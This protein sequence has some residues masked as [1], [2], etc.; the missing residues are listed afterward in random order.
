MVNAITNG[1]KLKIDNAGRI[2]LPK[3]V[4]DRLGLRAG[5]DLE[6]AESGEGILL[7]P[8]RQQPSLIRRNGLLIHCGKLPKGYEWDRLVDEDREGRFKKLT[9]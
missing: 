1:M 6:L 5:S 7:T 8:A 4:R 9:G 2:V 3:P